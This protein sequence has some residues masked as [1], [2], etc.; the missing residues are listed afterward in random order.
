MFDIYIKSINVDK[1]RNLTNIS[2]PISEDEKRNII[3]TGKNGSGKTSLLNAISN[4]CFYLMSAGDF[5]KIEEKIRLYKK[6]YTNAEESGSENEKSRWKAEVL[7]QEKA[8][9]QA[10]AGVR[11]GFNIPYSS[12]KSHF[13]KGDFIAAYFGATRTFKAT[14]PQHIERV[15]LKECYSMKEEPRKD[16]VMYITD[17]KMKEALAKTSGNDGLANSIHTWFMKFDQLLKNVFEDDTTTLLFDPE[18]FE[19]TIK[20]EEKESFGFNVLSDG[21]AAVLDIIVDLM[22][23]MERQNNRSFAYDLPGIVL[24]DEIETH[25]HLELQRK[26]MGM[27][28]TLFPNIQFIVTTHSPFILNS[29]PNAVIYDLEKNILVEDGLNDISYGGIVEGY[30]KADQ[31][32]ID[33]RDKFERYKELVAKEKVTDADISEIMMLET[34]LDE[35]PD[36][37]DLGIST[38]FHRLKLQFQSRGDL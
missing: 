10:K 28:T 21:Y 7:G 24:I 2:I 17:L 23:R 26:V 19:F 34:Y 8:L 29:T 31:L 1:V 36:Y 13:D 16:F 5:A 25:L 4:N 27:L 38:E 32:S 12:L 11:V 15:E 33:L 6:M 14:I 22:M 20:Q 9:E 30:F 18:T 37:L 3:I 35:I